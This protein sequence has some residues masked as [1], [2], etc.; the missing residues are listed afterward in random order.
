MPLLGVMRLN[1]LP[2]DKMESGGF[3][4]AGSFFG[5]S[6]GLF[7]RSLEMLFAGGTGFQ[8]FMVG[9]RGNLTLGDYFAPNATT[10]D[11]NL[12]QRQ[13]TIPTK[14]LVMTNGSSWESLDGQRRCRLT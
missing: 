5:C 3:N 10:Y 1:W 14:N 6:I 9:S 2:G 11:A 12:A 8:W 7:V 4:L 13:L